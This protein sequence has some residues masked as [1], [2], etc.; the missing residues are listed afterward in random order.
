MQRKS[1]RLQ[2]CL[3]CGRKTRKQFCC[4]WHER[5]HSIG[6]RTE[7]KHCRGCK[8]EFT[9]IYESQ[10][11]C[12]SICWNIANNNM[13]VPEE[14]TIKRREPLICVECLE[15]FIPFGKR[16]KYCSNA[17]YRKSNSR[18]SNHLRRVKIANARKD[19]GI[20]LNKLYERDH[21]VCH[22]CG[23][24]CCKEDY[25]VMDVGAMVVGNSYPS[26][27]HV[28]ALANGGTHTWDNVSLAH[29]VCNSIKGDR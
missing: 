8:K 9:T 25:V 16:N 17:C 14:K 3:F 18:D 6:R 2:E 22:I 7:V 11:Y 29:R 20:T 28:I 5:L 15:E 4:I 23:G 13:F 1:A 26:I 21:G 12:T 24:L 10:E 19:L 27:D